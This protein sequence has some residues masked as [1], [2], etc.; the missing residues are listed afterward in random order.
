MRS[1]PRGRLL[2]ETQN[3]HEFVRRF[4]PAPFSHG[5]QGRVN[6]DLM[7]DTREFDC[8]TGCVETD[9]VVVRDRR[10]RRSRFSLRLPTVPELGAGLADAGF[11]ASE[12]RARHG[13][14]PAI[15]RPRLV[16]PATA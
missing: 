12:F 4:T 14:P 13:R 16:V 6:D 11:A 8:L 5:M 15:D 2:L 3:H 1:A 7:I 10:V 9:R